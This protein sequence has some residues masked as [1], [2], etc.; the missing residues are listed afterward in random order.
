MNL[1]KYKIFLNLIVL[2]GVIWIYACELSSAVNLGW[3]KDKEDAPYA[4]N[5]RHS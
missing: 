2:R 1:Y 4:V 5:T 3:P